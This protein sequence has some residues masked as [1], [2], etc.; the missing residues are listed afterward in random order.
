M[1]ITKYLTKTRAKKSWS[2]HSSRYDT[3]SIPRAP[4]D[5]TTSAQP[6]SCVSRMLTVSPSAAD[7]CHGSAAS[8]GCATRAGR[9]GGSGARG[10][11]GG[12]F[13]FGGGGGGLGFATGLGC[14]GGDGG[15]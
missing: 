6:S 7:S 2:P 5:V 4:S 8:Y 14:G 1:R 11:G 10:G 9:D 13:G 12:G 3:G 15:F